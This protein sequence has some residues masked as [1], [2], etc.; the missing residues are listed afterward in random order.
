MLVL[1]ANI[2]IRAVLGRRVWKLLETYAGRGLR[3]YAPEAAYADAEKYLPPLLEKRGK[4]NADLTATLEDLKSLVEPVNRDAYEHL[5]A[6]AKRASARARRG[7]LAD[8][9]NRPQPF[10]RHLD[11]GC[12]FL[13]RW[14]GAM[15]LRP[16]RN[17]SQESGQPHPTG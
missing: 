1:D 10:V 2:L 4:S 13:R 12:R 7:R 6:E 8:S 11:R 15:D 3:F 9:R 17:L 16:R 5:E 14:S